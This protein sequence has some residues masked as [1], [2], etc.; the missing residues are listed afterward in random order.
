[1]ATKEEFKP[2]PEKPEDTEAMLALLEAALY[3]AGR[4][5]DLNTLNSI[6]KTR[7]KKKSQALVRI[8]AQRYLERKGALQLLELD[9]GRFVLQLKPE[10]ASHVRRLSMR[11]LLPQS[12]LRTLAYIAYRQPVAQAHLAAMRGSQVYIHIKEL[13]NLG[14][15]T[16][17]KLGRTKILRTTEVY[18]DY[19]N[20][21]HDVRLMKRQLKSLFDSEG[22]LIDVAEEESKVP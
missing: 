16:V 12:P 7:S 17:E 2:E 1:L 13:E 22:K 19:F 8:L 6:I 21:S 9:D 3:V 5:L 11:P 10:Y 20:L 18:A 15:I 14:L 4:P